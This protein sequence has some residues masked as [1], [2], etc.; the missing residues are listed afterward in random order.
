MPFICLGCATTY[1]SHTGFCSRCWGAAIVPLGR[2]PQ[3]QVDGTPSITSAQALVKATWTPAL[4]RAVPDL[5]LGRGAL[6]VLFG[7]P[8]GGKSTFA[9]RWLSGCDGTRLL[10]SIEEGTGPALSDRLVRLGIHDARLL[11]VSN[12][13]VDAVVALAQRERVRVLAVDSVQRSLF[14]AAELR[15]LI[16][17]LDLDALLAIAQVNARGEILGRRELEHEADTVLSIEAMRWT[18]TKHRYG[19]TGQQ[20]SVLSEDAA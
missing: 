17:V 1:D 19:P 18:T 13:S 5:R 16:R 12:A 2:R 10:V 4:S 11:I 14:E 8:G 6:V 9:L 3:A 7:P 15:H 20:G